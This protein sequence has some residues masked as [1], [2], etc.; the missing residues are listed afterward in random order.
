MMDRLT[1]GWKRRPPLYGPMA[2]EYCT[3]K[4]RLTWRKEN[5]GSRWREVF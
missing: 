4:P 1:E 2:L 5:K 3:R